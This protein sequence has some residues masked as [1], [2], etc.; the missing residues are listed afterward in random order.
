MGY[1]TN[2]KP[3]KI[4]QILDNKHNYVSEC[5]E[6]VLRNSTYIYEVRSYEGK[7][8]V[9]REVGVPEI[10]ILSYNDD[11]TNSAAMCVAHH[12]D[13]PLHILEELSTHDNPKVRCR[14]A[15]NPNV[16][17]SLRAKMKEDSDVYVLMEV[18]RHTKDPD[19]L[20]YLSDNARLGRIITY[21]KY[22]TPSILKKLYRANDPEIWNGLAS[23][24]NTPEEVLLCLSFC[25]YWYVVQ[26]L[27]KNPSTP[28]L[29]I[30][31]L[32][33]N[34]DEE[35]RVGAGYHRRNNNNNILRTCTYSP[36][37]GFIQRNWISLKIWK[38]L[39]FPNT[40]DIDKYQREAEKEL[41]LFLQ[42]KERTSNDKFIQC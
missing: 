42:S 29:V 3:L 6:D 41:E 24:K 11:T 34:Q 10:L 25:N 27:V 15:E 38:E 12:P 39:I 20:N 7:I 19:I 23:N 8:E 36:I 2:H 21:N 17:D 22:A 1:I 30:Q 5:L 16:S 31:K 18:A 37:W 32:M 33:Y 9:L 26:E 14:V 40:K 13:T 28:P 35:I 4:N